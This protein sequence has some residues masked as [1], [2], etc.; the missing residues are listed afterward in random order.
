MLLGVMTLSWWLASRGLT[1]ALPE[2]GDPP[3]ESVESMGRAHPAV[4]ESV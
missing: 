3:L 2:R 4:E 1:R